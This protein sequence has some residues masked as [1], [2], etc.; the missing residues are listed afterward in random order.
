LIL[1]YEADRKVF[2]TGVRLPPSPPK[3]I[4]EVT[5]NKSG[6]RVRASGQDCVSSVDSLP[7]R[8]LRRV[9][10]NATIT[11]DG[12]AMVSTGQQVNKWT[13]RECE[14][15]RIGVTRSKKQKK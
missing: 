13:A 10:E 9:V 4:T 7:N 6:H 14:T 15:R 12:D 8:P 1:L 11:F 5:R 3:V 2:W